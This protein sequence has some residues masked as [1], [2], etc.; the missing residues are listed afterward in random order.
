[1]SCLRLGPVLE[2]GDGLV[3]QGVLDEWSVGAINTP[4]IFG[5]YCLKHHTGGEKLRCQPCDTGRVKM[6]QYYA[7]SAILIMV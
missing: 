2:F 5:L 6:E 1:M 7:K 3:G 4:K